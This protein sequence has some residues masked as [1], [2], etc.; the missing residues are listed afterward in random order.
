VAW[1]WLGRTFG[2]RSCSEKET[3]REE[4]D[5]ALERKGRVR[6]VQNERVAEEMAMA[7]PSMASRTTAE[8]VRPSSPASKQLSGP[9]RPSPACCIHVQVSLTL[10]CFLSFLLALPCGRRSRGGL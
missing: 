10:M 9:T 8:R 4:R 2:A 1:E 3:A 5:V 7:G 6:G